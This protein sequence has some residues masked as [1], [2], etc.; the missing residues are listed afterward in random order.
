MLDLQ[1]LDGGNHPINPTEIR[2]QDWLSSIVNGFHARIKNRQQQLDLAISPAAVQVVSDSAS[3]ERV[4]AE[5]LNNACKY[6]PPV[7]HIVLEVSPQGEDLI[8]FSIR[9]TGVEI[10]ASELSRI[11]EYFYRVPSADPW[12]QGGTGFGL[13]LVQRLLI[14][15]NSDIQVASGDN[16]TCF[17]FNLPRKLMPMA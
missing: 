1:R 16:Q 17:S 14:H 11:F 9:N 5:L 10:P 2:L 4:I 12:K 8:K 13:A 7:G 15:L 3:L 6:T